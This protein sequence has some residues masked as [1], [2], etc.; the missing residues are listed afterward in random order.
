MEHAARSLGDQ[1]DHRGRALLDPVRHLQCL[2]VAVEHF[3]ILA[4]RNL[5][6][7]NPAGPR[8]H[9]R[10]EVLESMRT[11]ERIDPDE[12]PVAVLLIAAQEFRDRRPRRGLV[13][14]RDRILEVEDHHIRCAADRLGHLLLAVA[15]GEQPGSHLDR[16]DV[17]HFRSGSSSRPF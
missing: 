7:H 15:G 11:V 8:G 13:L 4:A 16:G 14:D 9:H 5:W 3:H 2:E 1:H 10:G 12:Q 6:E 17:G